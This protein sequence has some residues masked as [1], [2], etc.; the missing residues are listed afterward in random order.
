MQGVSSIIRLSNSHHL[1]SLCVLEKAKPS[2]EVRNLFEKKTYNMENDDL[3]NF[4]MP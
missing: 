1:F 3:E 2:E 4:K